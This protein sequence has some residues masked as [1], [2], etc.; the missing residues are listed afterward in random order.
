[1]SQAGVRVKVMVNAADSTRMR[2]KGI[3]FRVD[4]NILS[5]GGIAG[6]NP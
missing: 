2:T 1:M 4:H 3:R 5:Q 6:L